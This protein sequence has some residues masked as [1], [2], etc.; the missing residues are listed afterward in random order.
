[1]RLTNLT[2]P[3]T[4]SEGLDHRDATNGG[5]GFA[6]VLAISALMFSTNNFFIEKFRI[7]SLSSLMTCEILRFDRFGCRESVGGGETP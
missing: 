2:R 7:S 3:C 4:I 6:G 5:F 1:M